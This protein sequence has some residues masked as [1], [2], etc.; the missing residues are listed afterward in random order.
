MKRSS[1]IAIAL[2]LL[3]APVRAQ[4][5]APLYYDL[6]PFS[7]TNPDIQK[8][9]ESLGVQT[10]ATL[11]LR[12]KLDAGG[13]P[14]AD[15]HTSKVA[16]WLVAEELIGAK[17][18][19]AASVY[20]QVLD[21]QRSSL[22]DPLIPKL[23]AALRAQKRDTEA[24]SWSFAHIHTDATMRE[25]CATA[26]KALRK[27]KNTSLGLQRIKG[28]L[29]GTLSTK[30]RRAL[31][32][33]AADLEALG[34]DKEAA[35]TR[36]RRIAWETSSQQTRREASQKLKGLGFKLG[37]L[38]E[39]AEIA[40]ETRSKDIK[41][42]RRTL[43]RRLRRTRN[44]TL[45]RVIIWAR[46]LIAGLDKDKRDDSLSVV[47]TYTRKLKGTP[48][49]PWALVGKAKALRRLNRDVE[50]AQ[51]YEDMGTRFSAHPLSAHA[52]VEGAGL[53]LAKGY[54][55]EADALYR[56]AL[57]L[58]QHGSA[59]REALWQVG[60]GAYLRGKYTEARK[61]LKELVFG[62]GSERD[63]LGTTWTERAQYWWA[64]SEAKLGEG[65]EARRLYDELVARFPMGWYAILSKQRL[66]DLG[67][68]AQQAR[69]RQHDQLPSVVRQATL[70]YPVA[71]IKL[72]A[73]D[74][75]MAVLKSLSHCSQLPGSGRALLAALYRKKGEDKKASSILKRHGIFAEVPTPASSASY[76]DAFPLR[77]AESLTR[78]AAESQISAA[79]FAGL[80]FI[81]SR[82]NAKARSGA[83]AIGLAQLMPG[84]AKRVSKRAWGKGVSARALRR[85]K[86]NLSLG[87]ILL[88]RLLN[89]FKGN[90]TLALAAYNAGSG[91]A[92]SWLRKRGHLEADAFVETIPYDQTRRY[93]MRV[94]SMA[95]VYHQL[96]GLGAPPPSIASALPNALAPFEG[97][98]ADT[99]ATS[100]PEKR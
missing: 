43:K 22:L 85:A 4:A 67:G 87:A 3:A 63:G 44:V 53:Y 73:E 96:Y 90:T 30:T 5:E 79:W 89:R 56:K 59:Q 24:A 78:Y 93:V 9:F 38:E 81:E 46:A 17:D 99:Q 65:D 64:R 91:A 54:P 86:T 35:I 88:R 7:T 58:E 57:T 29:R 83:G 18:P 76:A 98:E 13:A 21:A 45:K 11:N 94:S 34:G 8:A 50:A 31:T 39:L 74:E 66:S 41:K 52:L 14:W 32:L 49:E 15:P 20:L 84:T 26:S 77:Y 72:G 27:H 71:L 69:A 92:T 48:A 2:L 60:F 33:L 12:R 25:S 75:A 68:R 10:E 47:S 19:D 6:S 80:I 1:L 36:L 55:R 42:V 97:S 82:F 51:V 62:Y 61:R 23:S 40:F 70:D 37:D 28:L 100:S 95:Q 16:R